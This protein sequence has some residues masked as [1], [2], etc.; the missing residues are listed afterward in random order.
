M[1]QFAIC[2]NSQ[3][4]YLVMTGT[5]PA[6]TTTDEG[7]QIIC[8]NSKVWLIVEADHQSSLRLLWRRPRSTHLRTDWMTTWQIWTT[9][10]LT[11]MK[12]IN[13]K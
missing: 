8:S 12:S 5:G 7:G 9:E 2:A 11:L 1:T 6:Y 4:T 13:N 3:H 10:K